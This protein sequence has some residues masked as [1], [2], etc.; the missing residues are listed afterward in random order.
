MP[1]TPRPSPKSTQEAA[2]AAAYPELADLSTAQLRELQ[3]FGR[4]VL[5]KKAKDMRREQ[6]L[7]DWLAENQ[8][9]LPL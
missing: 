5:R 1:D 3:A 9:E 2:F 4:A 7:R 6:A 8:L